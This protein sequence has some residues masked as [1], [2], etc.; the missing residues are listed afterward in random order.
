MKYHNY[1]VKILDPK[2]IWPVEYLRHWSPKK[3]TIAILLYTLLRP[4]HIFNFHRSVAALWCLDHSLQSI[5][6]KQ[7]H[8]PHLVEEVPCPWPWKSSPT[9]LPRWGAIVTSINQYRR[10]LALHGRSIHTATCP[11]K[12][13]DVVSETRR[14]Q[15]G[16]LQPHIFSQITNL[17]EERGWLRF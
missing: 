9:D 15:P 13:D 1:Y 8:M 10:I 11:G 2:S 4:F 12:H 14:H 16:L 5:R 7:W 6:E 3:Y 17:W